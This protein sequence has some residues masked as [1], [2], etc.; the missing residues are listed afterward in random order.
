[1]LNNI[2]QH[3]GKSVAGCN[4]A[5]EYLK[6]IDRQIESDIR[7]DVG[8]VIDIESI[9]KYQE[10]VMRDILLLKEHIKKLKRE[11]KEN[12]ISK[13]S[14]DIDDNFVKEGAGT[15]KLYVC[16]TPF[17]RAICGI[18]INSVVS[19]GKPFDKVYDYLTTKY[20]I[21]QREELELLQTLSDMGQPIFK[22]RGGLPIPDDAKD[23]S[24]LEELEEELS[25][26]DFITNYFA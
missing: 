23:K 1:M 17:T 21:T 6:T 18:L 13:N 20:N 26:V 2:P 8:H 19:A 10:R 22:D 14:S 9:A 3:D 16:I 15:V 11:F 12:A 25:G 4:R 5:I 7:D 24:K